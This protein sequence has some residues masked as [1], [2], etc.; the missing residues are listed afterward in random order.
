MAMPSI[1][2]LPVVREDYPAGQAGVDK[3]IAKIVAYIHEGRSN[4]LA[5]QFAEGIIRAAGFSPNAKLSNRQAA[6][7][8]VDY[9]RDNV[10]YR[11]DAHMTETVQNPMVTLCVPGAAACIPVGDCDDGTAV[12]GWLQTAYGIPVRLLI[13]HFNSNTDHVLLEVQDDDGSWLA[14]DF[15]NFNASNNPVGW[16]P[17]AVSEY[18]IDPFSSENLQVAG[19]RDVEFVAVG[20][21]PMHAVTTLAEVPRVTLGRLPPRSLGATPMSVTGFAQASTDLANE[22]TAV[23]AAG[24][25]Y[26]SATPAEPA[27]ALSSYKAA[28]QAGAT[29]VG[30]EI[31]LAGAA[32][33]T[34]PLTHQAWVTNGDLQAITGTDAA[35]LAQAR[36]LVTNMQS[37]WQQAINDGT[38]AALSGKGPPPASGVGRLLGIAAII[39]VAGGLAYSWSKR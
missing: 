37:L 3:A 39:G 35:S 19:A 18:R 4:P 36:L 24:D 6:Q 8:F 11:P 16:K 17:N 34:Q 13:Q 32:W 5:R 25:T 30:P 38:E 22:V 14:E 10:R 2:G 31:D 9:L 15:S 21:V 7:A 26:A 29:V 1:P 28:G 33:A 12:L 27:S 23:I 20:R